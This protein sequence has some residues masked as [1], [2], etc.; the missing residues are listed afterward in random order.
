MQPYPLSPTFTVEPTFQDHFFENYLIDQSKVDQQKL[1]LRIPQGESF[2]QFLSP[3]ALNS[4]DIEQ[5]FRPFLDDS[6]PT[7]TIMSPT[8]YFNPEIFSEKTEESLESKHEEEEEERKNSIKKEIDLSR[9]WFTCFKND[10]LV[11]DGEVEIII[12]TRREKA[13]TLIPERLYSSLKYEMQITAKGDFVRSLPFLLARISVVD[14]TTLEP[15][16]K[17]DKAVMKGENESALTHVPSGPKDLVKGTIK[18]QFDSSISYHHDRREVALEIYFFMNDDLE[19]P[20]LTKRSVPVKMFARKPNKKKSKKDK[21]QSTNKR[22]RKVEEEESQ[23]KVPK[24]QYE[25]SSHF[26][27]FMECLD[28]LVDQSM[29]LTCE[30][31]QRATGMMLSKFGIL[32]PF[33]SDDSYALYHLQNSEQ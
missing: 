21:E 28:K 6:S 22:K 15:V 3:D 7:Q 5:I 31:R 23:L 32:L 8:H 9:V 33:A 27:N 13:T 19:R 10:S 14:A 1:H 16:S 17:K 4:N 20:I 24:M 11:G 30:E 2:L 12:K 29:Y 25:T 26:Q 18:V